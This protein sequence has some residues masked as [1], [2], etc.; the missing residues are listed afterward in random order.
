MQFPLAPSPP[1]MR[2]AH[3]PKPRAHAGQG[4]GAVPSQGGGQRASSSFSLAAERAEPERGTVPSGSKDRHV[5]ERG[6]L[7]LR[8]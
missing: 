3:S 8:H 4:R 5:R 6:G 2:A 1:G 7:L